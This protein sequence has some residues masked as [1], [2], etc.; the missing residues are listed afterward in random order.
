MNANKL[1]D[2]VGGTKKMAELCEVEP[3]AVS[4]WRDSGIPKARLMFLKLARPHLFIA[5]IARAKRPN[6]YCKPEQ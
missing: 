4:Q 2:A 5:D 1:I 6:E 3:S